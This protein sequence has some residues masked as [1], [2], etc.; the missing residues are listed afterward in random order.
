MELIGSVFGRYPLAL[1][2]VASIGFALGVSR[3]GIVTCGWPLASGT[4]L[5][6]LGYNSDSETPSSACEGILC[7]FPSL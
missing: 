5:V 4:G 3:R 1:P 6:V 7:A 2:N